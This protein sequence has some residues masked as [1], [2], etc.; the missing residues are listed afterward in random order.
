MPFSFIHF[1]QDTFVIKSLIQDN[2]MKKI[3]GT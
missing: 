3:A 2:E 1:N